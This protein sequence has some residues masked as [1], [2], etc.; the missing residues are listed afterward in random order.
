MPATC[1]DADADDLVHPERW[2][3]SRERSHARRLLALRR[4]R[5]KRG[6][7]SLAAI[8]A[9]ALTLGAGGAFAASTGDASTVLKKG[10]RGA[11][12]VQ[13]QQKLDIPADGV[14]GPQTAKAVRRYQR[15][16][17]LAVDGVV[18]PQTASALGISLAKAKADSL[19]SSRGSGSGGKVRLPAVL[20]SI[21]QCESGGNP[22]AISPGG[23]Y[24]GKYQFDRATWAAYGPAGDPAR[25]SEAEQ[26]R[27]ALKLYKARGTQPWPNCA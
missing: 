20:H 11:V 27:R 4:R 15:S 9:A 8:L 12:V 13:L 21:A 6:S 26:D 7:R 25:A 5:R 10:S 16:K 22:R 1:P 23:T 18:G 24:R 17:G 19:R 2:E 14:F 3:R